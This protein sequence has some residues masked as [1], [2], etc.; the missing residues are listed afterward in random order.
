[1]LGY[2]LQEVP[3][4]SN[5][6]WPQRSILV[7]ASKPF[8]HTRPRNINPG[9][10]LLDLEILVVAQI[11]VELFGPHIRRVRFHLDCYAEFTNPYSAIVT[12][13][14]LPIANWIMKREAILGH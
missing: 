12:G 9:L 5:L 14:P 10:T 6:S 11:R 8:Y 13:R 2:I 4:Q 1:V 7:Q 3:D